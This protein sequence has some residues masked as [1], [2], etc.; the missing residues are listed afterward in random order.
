KDEMTKRTRTIRLFTAVALAASAPTAVAGPR[1]APGSET[2]SPRRL[3]SGA[4][5]CGNVQ[6]KVRRCPP[7]PSVAAPAVREIKTPARPAIA[8]RAAA[9]R[10]P[11]A[12]RRLPAVV[13]RTTTP[14]VRPRELRTGAPANGNIA[15]RSV[16]RPQAPRTEAPR[17]ITN[18]N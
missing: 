4:P 12:L 17:T 7:A 9:S 10:P 2:V 18:H 15:G 6:V 1:R 8:T 13:G 3:P 16:A 11:A 5:A 14:V